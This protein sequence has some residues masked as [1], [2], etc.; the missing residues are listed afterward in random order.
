MSELVAREAE[1]HQAPGKAT[2]QLIELVVVPGSCSSEWG[3]ILNEHSPASER[4]EVYLLP[5]QAD[6]TEI[7]ERLG[8]V[9]HA[10]VQWALPCGV[11]L[12]KS[13]EWVGRKEGFTKGLWAFPGWLSKTG[14]PPANC[15]NKAVAPPIYSRWTKPPFAPPNWQPGKGQFDIYEQMWIIHSLLETRA[16]KVKWGGKEGRCHLFISFFCFVF[17]L[18][19]LC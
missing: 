12:L 9:R 4:V 3:H 14:C 18:P 5:I 8:N 15:L 13:V 7:V 19:W 2:L 17:V 1:N 10:E 6:G 11:S 16:L